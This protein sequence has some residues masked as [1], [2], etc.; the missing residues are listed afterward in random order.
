MVG[1]TRG[2]PLQTGPGARGEHL[3]YA[4]DVWIEEGQEDLIELRGVVLDALGLE[5]VFQLGTVI[6]AVAA[7]VDNVLSRIGTQVGE[8][9]GTKTFAVAIGFSDYVVENPV[10]LCSCQIQRSAFPPGGP[11]FKG[12]ERK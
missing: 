3:Q 8:I 2:A 5:M 11:C 9:A 1:R 10:A 6:K 4:T 7:W 12:M